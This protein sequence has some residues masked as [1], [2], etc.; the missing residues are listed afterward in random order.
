MNK[1]TNAHFKRRE[2]GFEETNLCFGSHDLL[3]AQPNQSRGTQ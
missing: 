1:V 2:R 3:E